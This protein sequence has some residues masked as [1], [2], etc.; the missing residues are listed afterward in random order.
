MGFVTEN[1]PPGRAGLRMRDMV[2]AVVVLVAIIGV[3]MAF[4]GGCT[5]SP[6]KATVDPSSVPTADAAGAL[7][8]TA[9]SADFAVRSPTVPKGWHANSTSTSPVGSGATANVIVRVGWLTASHSYAQLSQSGGDPNDVLV[10]ETG[11]DKP[12]A[13]DGTVDVDGVT[14]TRYPARRDEPAWVTELNGT[15]LLITGSAQE[16]ELRELAHATQTANP[17]TR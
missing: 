12:P 5:F 8:S 2:G 4:Y 1:G 17:L 13:A 7:A 3:I 9:Q 6:G 16:S 14:W 15:V 11:R 10:K